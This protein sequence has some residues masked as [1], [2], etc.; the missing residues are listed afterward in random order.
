MCVNIHF[1]MMMMMMVSSHPLDFSCSFIWKR[2]E[3]LSLIFV[4]MSSLVCTFVRI[5]ESFL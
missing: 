1:G 2:K 3:F 5:V 4:G